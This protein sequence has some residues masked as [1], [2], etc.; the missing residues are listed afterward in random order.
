VLLRELA[1]VGV[2][3]VTDRLLAPDPDVRALGVDEDQLVGLVDML[4]EVVDPLLFHQSRDEVQVA[5]AVLDAVLVRDVAAAEAVIDRHRRL[6][7]EDRLQDVGRGR[8][9]EDPAVLGQAQEPEPGPQGQVVPEGPVLATAVGE[10]HRVAAELAD[11]VVVPG[12]LD[13]QRLAQQLLRVDVAA[14]GLRLERDLE[15]LGQPLGDPHP[16]EAQVLD[17]RGQ[18]AEPGH[19]RDAPR[20]YVQVTTSAPARIR[21]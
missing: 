4:E 21:R 8:F 13:R 3:Q 16:R 5:L 11:D 2:G 19:Q 15:R 6:V 12:H 7:L 14:I 17:R 18:L 20:R 9:L 10:S 1:P